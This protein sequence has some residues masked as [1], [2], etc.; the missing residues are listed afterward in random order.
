MVP[1]LMVALQ[2]ARLQLAGNLFGDR[3]QMAATPKAS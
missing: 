3:C 2:N 1:D